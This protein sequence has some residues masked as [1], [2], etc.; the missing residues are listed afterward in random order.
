MAGEAVQGRLSGQHKSIKEPNVMTTPVTSEYGNG[1][2]RGRLLSAEL[3]TLIWPASKAAFD[4]E[5]NPAP[6]NWQ[7][8]GV[9]ANYEF[10]PIPHD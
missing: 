1:E 2:P 9:A 6:L 8:R 3:R 7:A 4:P 10:R 5:R